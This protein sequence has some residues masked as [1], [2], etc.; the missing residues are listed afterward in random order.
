MPSYDTQTI[1]RLEAAAEAAKRELST[2]MW[3]IL[4]EEEFANGLKFST[5]FSRSEFVGLNHD[6]F[7]EVMEPITQVLTGKCLLL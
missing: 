1:G 2:R 4:E 5:G 3:S 7:C 6:L